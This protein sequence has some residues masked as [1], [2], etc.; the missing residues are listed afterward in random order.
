MV[1]IRGKLLTTCAVFLQLHDLSQSA[2]FAR[3]ETLS[4]RSISRGV[5]RSRTI[6]LALRQS[7]LLHTAK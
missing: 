5:G 1:S 2:P 7:V 3:T 4:H 6:S